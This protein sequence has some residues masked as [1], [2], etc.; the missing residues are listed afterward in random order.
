MF[1]L[2][3]K[4][5]MIT[6]TLLPNSS[7]EI[8]SAILLSNCILLNM[9][10]S[11][12]IGFSAFASFLPSA[13]SIPSCF[14][15]SLI[16]TCSC[17]LFSSLIFLFWSLVRYQIRHCCGHCTGGSSGTASRTTGVASETAAYEMGVSSSNTLFSSPGSGSRCH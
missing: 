12:L 13:P 10:G 3:L 4:A 1:I 9:A 8:M 11:N 2:S 6:N 17:S 7:S 5:D 16:G 14:F 15:L